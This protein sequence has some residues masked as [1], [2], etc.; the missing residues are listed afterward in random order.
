MGNW[1][2]RSYRHIGQYFDCHG[3]KE[4]YDKVSGIC[5]NWV[6]VHSMYSTFDS[7]MS[8]D[9]ICETAK[10][11]GCRNVTLTDHGNML[12]Y[13]AFMKSGEKYGINTIPGVE[14][15][16]ENR[17][18]M[19][20]FAR[21][22]K[23]FTDISHAMRE[24]NTHIEKVKGTTLENAIMTR[25]ICEQFFKGNTDVVCTSACIMG[26]ISYILL[27][28]HR[29][30]R[31]HLKDFAKEKELSGDY[32]L[33]NEA[34]G[35]Y[36]S[37]KKKIN[38]LKTEKKQ[39]AKYLTPGY[40]KKIDKE[41]ARLDG[42]FEEIAALERGNLDVMINAKENAEKI[43][44]TIDAEIKEETA[45]MNKAQ[46]LKKTYKKNADTYLKAKAKMDEIVWYTENELYERAKEELRW[47]KSVFPLFFIEIQYHGIDEEAYVMPILIKL[48]YEEDVP[49][50]AANDAHM[51][52]NSA[53]SI[54]ARRIV[55]YNYFKKAQTVSPADREL[56]L[57]TDGELAAWLLKIAPQDAV[58][59]AIF[60]TRILDTCKV[61]FPAEEHYPSVNSDV[62]FTDMI[63]AGI[64]RRM[65]EGSIEEW[66]KEYED[67]KNHELKVMTD[68]GYVDYH[69]VVE[70]FCR[71][72]RVLGL[73]PAECVSS[74]PDDYSLMHEWIKENHFADTCGVGIGPGRGSAVGSL[75]CFLLGITNLDPIKYNLLFERFLNPER[76]SM[77][78]IDTDIATRIRPLL[79]KYL[80]W[81]YGERAVCSIAT[82]TTYAAKGAIQMAGRDRASEK[83]AHLNKKE[84]NEA[85]RKY[86]YKYTL[87][88]SDNI[89]EINN[90]TL[91]ESEE[92]LK[93]I[94]ESDEEFK[95]I[96]EHAKLIEGK[97]Q[98]TSVHAGGVIISDNDNI[99]DYVPLAYN[100]E[101]D[102]WAAQCDMI[103]AEEK[104]L[105]KMDMLGLST[106]DVISGC[107]SNVKKYRGINVDIGKVEFESEVFEKIYASG[108]TNS[109]FQFESSG[110]KNMLVKFR[111][112]SFEDIILLVACYRPG[113]LQYLDDI[114][115]VKNK[116]K[117]LTYKTPELESILKDTYGAVV[118]QE[119]VM[120]IFQKLAGY[121][122][123]GADI[124]RRAM[125]K[126]K[127]K[128]LEKERD[129][130]I[131][132]D[133]ERNIDGCVKRG[134]SAE[135]A[136]VLFDEMME[137]AKYA[138]NKSHAA[139]YAYVSYQTAW[140][141]C[142]YPVE[143]MCAMF[144]VK[145]QDEYEPVI[146]DCRQ[147]GIKLLPPDINASYYDF[148]IEGNSIRY[149]I[150]GIKGV[151]AANNES[152]ESLLH[153]RKEKPYENMND[154]LIRNIRTDANG[155]IHAIQKSMY[156]KLCNSGMFDVFGYERKSLVSGY[157]A[158][159]RDGLSAEALKHE[160][161]SLSFVK[162]SDGGYNLKAEVELL[163]AVISFDP[164]DEY[165]GEE[166]YGCVPVGELSGHESEQD[167]SIMGFVTDVELKKNSWGDE[168]YQI[169]L[170]G[171]TGRVTVRT[172]RRM[173]DCIKISELMSRVIKVRG[174]YMYGMFF[175][176][177]IL[178][179]FIRP[180]SVEIY[181]ELDSEA[182]V[183]AFNTALKECKNDGASD[184][185]ARICCHYLV[186]K[187]GNLYK[188]NAPKFVERKISS[189]AVNYLK[190]AGVKMLKV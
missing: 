156:E 72:G 85:C 131:N 174:T 75:I 110:M 145:E 167:I 150:K 183:K 84:Y 115:K 159:N 63:D 166:K 40:Q 137:F 126:K 172:D 76:V 180:N 143:Y 33:Y 64:K 14:T 2:D 165:G 22:H 1:I 112:D 65:E 87:K 163:G 86:M 129:V 16:R 47:Y 51:K 8:T 38:E 188:T 177:G 125:S 45:N 148:V 146:D 81:K 100:T 13:T 107:I 79:I 97:L 130:F 62:K 78:D 58:Y 119:Q 39:Y 139:A 132:G 15:Y 36:D 189:D 102:V 27:T 29:T 30:K 94:I 93:A 95:I 77:P 83:Y 7:T 18:H 24:A 118:Y 161:E 181:I 21:N 35:T 117:P 17:C 128:V 152:I 9:E 5:N 71:E 88:L 106:L 73:I 89:P 44:D 135:I 69:K 37:A 138:F 121:S 34:C 68:M 149:G 67:R 19:I 111:P 55:R 25:D 178:P 48:A 99:N 96:W 70:D 113:P 41:K 61:I 160:I 123:G 154:F 90:I 140:L 186:D 52:D 104:G 11:K 153:I 105:L 56:Y 103:A 155:K 162:G 50:I 169:K 98:G 53:D 127:V 147:M 185:T 82:E 91:I 120:Q 4:F 101:K 42:M 142:H 108:M 164:L 80:K 60:N 23:G 141:K 6:H 32:A 92:A 136:N 10:A 170:I 144:N 157:M 74:A 12:G 122:L 31:A 28:N 116:E 49:L 187:G 175:S 57:K 46:E 26:T 168:I 109:V 158:D 184:V 59:E 171:K 179:E 182:S 133:T 190:N 114:I 54:E 176:K 124:V 43:T 3:K 66:T 134:I 151:G 173:R 20:L